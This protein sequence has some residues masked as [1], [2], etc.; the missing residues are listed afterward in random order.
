MQLKILVVPCLFLWK[1]PVIYRGGKISITMFF[2]IVVFAICRGRWTSSIK[3]FKI[4][5][6]FCNL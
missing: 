3:S 4:M 2:D 6:S 1:D 5:K